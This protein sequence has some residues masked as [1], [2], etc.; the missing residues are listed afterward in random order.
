MEAYYKKVGGE[1]VL[2]TL[3]S[4]RLEDGNYVYQYTVNALL[5]SPKG[6]VS[7]QEVG[8]V[9]IGLDL[10]LPS[11]ASNQLNRSSDFPVYSEF[12]PL[13]EKLG[14]KRVGAA[15]S[16]LRYNPRQKRYEQFFEGVGMYRLESDPPGRAKLLAYGAWKCG[17]ACLYP[18]PAQ[19]EV[20]PPERVDSRVSDLVGRLGVDL[21]GFPLLPALAESDGREIVIFENVVVEIPIDGQGEAKLLPLPQKLGI[22]PEGLVANQENEQKV[23]LSLHGDKGHHIWRSFMS[24]LDAHGGVELVGLPITEPVEWERGSI[25]Q[26]FEN[27]CLV[28]DHQI[29]GVYRIRPSPLGF[30]YASLSF[31]SE[32]GGEGRLSLQSGQQSATL[33]AEHLSNPANQE[34][35]L[36]ILEAKPFVDQQT[37]QEIGVIVRIGGRLAMDIQPTLHLFFPNGEV[38]SFEM[39]PTNEEGKSSFTIPPIQ[40]PNG[41]LVEY[42]ICIKTPSG[43]EGCA[44]D[45]YLIWAP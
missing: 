11:I 37:Q 39:P 5:F 21:T 28:E 3:I 2:G 22:L 33:A 12:L 29:E 43:V 41:T 4:P 31:P 45:D 13:Y 16:G 27:L 36:E 32:F 6:L 18:V 10:N 44:S 1:E 7:E 26:C 20:I 42:R 19:A 9:P 34:I 24:Y 8:F 35:T 40:A 23:F 38:S 15:L 14:R 30:E 17:A 25:R